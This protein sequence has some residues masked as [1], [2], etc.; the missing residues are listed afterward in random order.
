MKKILF[1]CTGNSVR[2]Q[3]AEGIG[4]NLADGR[5]EVRSAGL[6]PMGIHPRAV[7]TMKDIGIDITANDSTFLDQSLLRWA[8]YVVILCS[9]ARGKIPPL[10]PGVRLV[11][12]DIKNPDKL[13]FSEEERDRGF[14]A[15]R[16]EIKERI[17]EFFED[18][19]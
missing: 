15:V 11:N 2:S 7:K 18:I 9:E 8:D 12:W 19:E 13:Y 5:F 14:A 10:P 3:I 17:E 4:R 6:A 16:D 1:V